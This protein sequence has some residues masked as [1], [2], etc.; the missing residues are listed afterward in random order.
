MDAVL[1]ELAK[2][3]KI[4]TFNMN[5]SVDPKTGKPSNLSGAL[6]S[7][8]QSLQE[9]KQQVEAGDS[10]DIPQEITKLIQD[11][12]K[13]VDDKQKEIHSSL[14][15][16]GKAIDKKFPEP[17]P[18]YH[19]MF[20]SSEAA[21]AL[22]RTVLN[23]FMRTGQFA[24]ANVLHEDSGIEVDP[25]QQAQLSEMYNILQALDG[26]DVTPALRWVELNRAFLKIRASSLEFHLYRSHYLRLLT[27]ADSPLPALTYLR[28][29]PPEIRTAHEQE[30]FRLTTSLAYFPLSKLASSPYADL[31]N[32]A[33]HSDLRQAFAREYCAHLGL[34]KQ[35][36]LRVVGDIGGRGALAKIEKGRRVMRENKNEW[37]Q[38]NELPTEIPVP[39]ENRYHSIF[40]CPVSKEQ[41]TET[42]PP[43]M[44]TCGH[45][46]SKDSLERLKKPQ[47]YT[48]VKC[49]YCPTE[50]FANNSLRVYF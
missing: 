39:P 25:Y 15:K 2:L 1:K 32:P 6:D 47:H 31:T 17:V 30:F 19:E 26:N 40:A 16:L 8:L 18:A 21:K 37:S 20:T 43:M 23:H 29:F 13:D 35:L 7:L 9:L 27:T 28:S 12:K 24:S 41:A 5:G 50:S 22:E 36:P 11:K 4:Q 10:L 44:M 46:V 42:N 3:E 33:L 34:S 38:S 14:N 49:P 48:R 45:V